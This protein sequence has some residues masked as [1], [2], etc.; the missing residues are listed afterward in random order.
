MAKTTIDID[1]PP[2]YWKELRVIGVS[3]DAEN[4]KV[5]LVSFTRQPSDK[6]LREFHDRLTK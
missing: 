3:R 6:E 4:N 5:L 2:E 1:L